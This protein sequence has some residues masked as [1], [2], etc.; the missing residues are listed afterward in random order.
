[1]QREGLTLTI[2]QYPPKA[3][4]VILTSK[5]RKKTR[6][7]KSAAGLAQIDIEDT[8]KV[9]RSFRT[10]W[11]SIRETPKQAKLVGQSMSGSN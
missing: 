5:S 4:K 2:E 11:W 1:M 7:P 3:C 9:L 8:L 6:K 10:D